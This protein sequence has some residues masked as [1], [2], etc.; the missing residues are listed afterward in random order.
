MIGD[1]VVLASSG[2]LVL[3]LFGVLRWGRIT[4]PETGSVGRPD[5]AV[6]G[7]I[8]DPG[9]AAFVAGLD[10]ASVKRLFTRERRRL[11]IAWAHA[12]RDEAVQLFQRHTHLVRQTR[13]IRPL[14]ELRVAWAFLT[15]MLAYAAIVGLIAWRGPFGM[16]TTVR[17]AELLERAVRGL[18]RHAVSGSADLGAEALRT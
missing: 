1:I 11:A 17:S 15:F 18:A 6:I 16:K 9:D 2:I 7:R 14:T 3:L 13:D 10:S 4:L 12:M 8:L 5:P